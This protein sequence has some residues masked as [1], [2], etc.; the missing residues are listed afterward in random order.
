MK[1]GREDNRRKAEQ[2]WKEMEGRNWKENGRITI[3]R[4]KKT[5]EVEGRNWKKDGRLTEGRLRSTRRR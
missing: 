1:G 2:Y 4:Q 5:E 3:R